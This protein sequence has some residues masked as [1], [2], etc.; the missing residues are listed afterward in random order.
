MYVHY[1]GVT[2]PMQNH[3]CVCQRAR[4]DFELPT[5]LEDEFALVGLL[6]QSLAKKTTGLLCLI[7][8]VGPVVKL[9]WIHPLMGLECNRHPSWL[10]FVERCYSEGA[11][12]SSSSDQCV[13]RNA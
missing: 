4:E 10:S 9:V 3:L 11:Q 12:K 2:C 1:S 6:I 7:T 5:R 8:H 13:L